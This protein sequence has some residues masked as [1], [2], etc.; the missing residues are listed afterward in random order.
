[1]NEKEKIKFKRIYLSFNFIC[2]LLIGL[3]FIA[4]ID[5]GNSYKEDYLCHHK[6]IK[7]GKDNTKINQEC[8]EVTQWFEKRG[9]GTETNNIDF[10]NIF[11]KKEK[12]KELE[13]WENA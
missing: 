12:Q 8:K 11:S 10:D 4:A 13:K 5:I 3:I 2:V 6:Y 7:Y 1:M 9:L